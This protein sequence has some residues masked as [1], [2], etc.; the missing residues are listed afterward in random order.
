MESN[1]KTMDMANEVLRDVLEQVGDNTVDNLVSDLSQA[2]PVELNAFVCGL[3]NGNTERFVYAYAT[4]NYTGFG[5]AMDR[6]VERF[7]LMDGLEQA[8]TLRKL[9]LLWKGIFLERYAV[10]GAEAS[11]LMAARYAAQMTSW[12]KLQ[13]VPQPSLALPQ[14][15]KIY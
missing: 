13:T 3:L 6:L 8:D 2:L 7:K 5:E 9:D 15:P 11:E 4:P 1:R 12:L 14:D 10:L